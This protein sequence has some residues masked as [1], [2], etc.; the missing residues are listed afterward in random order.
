MDT[1]NDR[2]M[3]AAELHR[4][5]T[6]AHAR[7]VRTRHETDAAHARYNLAQLH[8]FNVY[9]DPS[10]PGFEHGTEKADNEEILAYERLAAAREAE[11]KAEAA[12][13]VHA[14][15]FAAYLAE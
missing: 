13:E 14:E 7:L 8:S 10:A 1:Q 12:Y 3:K 2:T 11:A 5:A 6:T 15:E 9:A 4:K